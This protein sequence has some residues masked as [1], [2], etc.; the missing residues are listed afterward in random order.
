MA[1]A[2][3]NLEEWRQ[4]DDFPDYQVSNTGRIYSDLSRRILKGKNVNGYRQ[5]DF[6][7]DGQVYQRYVHDIVALAYILNPEE[8]TKVDH[9]DQNKSN[10]NVSNLRWCDGPRNG[11]NRGK[12]RNSHQ[13]YKGVYPK[14][15]KWQAQIMVN[16]VKYSKTLPTEV[17]AARWYN[18]K[19]AELSGEFSCPNIIEEDA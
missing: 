8:L 18:A 13:R 5:V 2:L 3:L 12:N 7:R 1:A 17:E 9:H 4:C 6:T 10:N 19:S 11:A 14:G 16:G 15:R